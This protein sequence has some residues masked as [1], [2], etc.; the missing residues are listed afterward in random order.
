MMTYLLRLLLAFVLGAVTVG[1]VSAQTYPQD[2]PLGT[3]V[4]AMRVHENG[5]VYWASQPG[6]LDQRPTD[7]GIDLHNRKVAFRGAWVIDVDNPGQILFARCNGGSN[8]G[9]PTF[10][11]YQCHNSSVGL[12]A[13]LGH[14][15]AW[16]AASDGTVTDVGPAARMVFMSDPASPFA[17]GNTPGWIVFQTTAPG[18]AT[19]DV[20]RST[21]MT[22]TGEWVMGASMGTRPGGQLS[23]H[24]GRNVAGPA[25]VQTY[26][27][28]R[29][30]IAGQWPE[31]LKQDWRFT[32][33]Q[34]EERLGAQVQV[35]KVEDYTDGSRQSAAYRLHVMEGG[36][37]VEYLRFGE[38]QTT[39]WR[40]LNLQ[41]V[42]YTTPGVA[43]RPLVIDD[44]GNVR[45]ARP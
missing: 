2:T 11:G 19:W 12:W 4:A 16:G 10:Q 25:V 9:D 13:Q 38:R 42:P 8:Q 34:G 36:T 39:L 45:R 33:S 7:F 3:G 30:A 35:S 15:Q 17:P 44:S 43:Y 1:P 32:N 24:T 27:H 22:S 18:S 28:D 31:Q 6:G 41:D 21:A 5:N 20:S 26:V 29:R 40:P 14:V 37:L 23:L